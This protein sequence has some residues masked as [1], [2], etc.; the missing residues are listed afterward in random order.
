MTHVNESKHETKV[1]PKCQG[2]FVCKVGD[3]GNCQCTTV[4]LNEDVQKYIQNT[5]TDCLC[6]NCLRE[7]GEAARDEI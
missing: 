1:C 7:I 6:C 3:V 5:Y 2:L 4:Q